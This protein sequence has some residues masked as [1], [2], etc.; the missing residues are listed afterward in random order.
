M[1]TQRACTSGPYYDHYLL[2]HY[3]D[4]TLCYFLFLI[5]RKVKLPLIFQTESLY[6]TQVYDVGG[7][8]VSI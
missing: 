2:C 8:L 4:S 1:A 6:I 5:C 3:S 7:V